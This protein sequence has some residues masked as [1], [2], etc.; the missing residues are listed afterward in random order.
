MPYLK[1][2]QR[3]PIRRVSYEDRQQIYQTPKWKKLR[4]AK[5]MQQP[6]CEV[7]LS[8]GKVTPAE[9]VHHIDS[10][11]NYNGTLRLWKAFDFAN[12]MSVCKE[13]HGLIHSD[14]IKVVNS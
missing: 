14:K 7:C 11:L 3:K 8:K 6:L 2:P 5:L 12:L 1:K 10:F 4:E 9:D 13:C